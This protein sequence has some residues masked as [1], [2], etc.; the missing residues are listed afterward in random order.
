MIAKQI[1]G[2][3]FIGAFTY[4]A[5]KM[6]LSDKNKRAEILGSNFSSL[7]KKLI[8]KEVRIVRNLRPNLSK[9]FYHT[10]L[11]FHP[12]EKIDNPTMMNIAETYLEKNGFDSNQYIV[13]RH[14]D[15]D[16][17]HIHLLINRIRFD[18]TVVSDSNDY[19]RSEKIVREIEKDFNL[20]KNISSKN[21][22]VRAP[23]K[24]E[25]EMVL[26]TKTPSK[27][28]ML[29]KIL[30]D[31]LNKSKNIPEFIKGCENEKIHLLFN[32]AS[33]GRI[34]GIS[35]LYDGFKMKGQQVGNAFKFSNI[36]KTLNYEQNADRSKIRGSNERTGEV[37]RFGGKNTI[38][39]IPGTENSQRDHRAIQ[40]NNG[41]SRG[42][43]Y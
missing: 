35:Y 27:K 10:A 34:S 25:L 19:K 37:E 16:H 33:T 1:K 8:D 9:Y 23:D 3:N 24:N 22:K 43:G 32:Q 6:H 13:F 39:G 7:E 14:H 28:M 36:S 42:I 29:Q 31:V 18:G 15:A 30:K 21:A 38:E 26:R 41:Y 5:K 40:E 20:Q 12:S 17:P 4:N 2:K 11:S